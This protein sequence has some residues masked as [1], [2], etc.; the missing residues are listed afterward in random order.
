MNE[1]NIKIIII[2]IDIATN[3]NGKDIRNLGECTMIWVYT[4][5]G[6]NIGSQ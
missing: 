3:N 2:I 4:A 5:R 6:N 1:K